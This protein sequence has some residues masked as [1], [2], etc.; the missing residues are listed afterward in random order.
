MKEEKHQHHPKEVM[1]L[2]LSYLVGV[3]VCI[4]CW[5]GVGVGFPYLST[6]GLV[7]LLSPALLNVG[8]G[9]RGQRYNRRPSRGRYGFV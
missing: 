8:F 1:C 6:F 7:H 2:G 3:V 4:P 9:L 5:V